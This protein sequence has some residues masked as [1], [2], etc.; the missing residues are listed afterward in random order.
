MV[1]HIDS[2]EAPGLCPCSGRRNP[3]E[4]PSR[5]K[6]LNLKPLNLKPL[7][8]KPLGRN[9]VIV[10]GRARYVAVIPARGGSKG[11]SR[12]N[13][14]S[15]AGR[16]LLAWTIDAAREAAT[17]LRVV[18]STD[19]E[20]IAELAVSLGAEVPCLRPATLATDESPSEDALLDA[21][22]SLPVSSAI[23]AVV[24]LQPTSPVRLAGSID[25][26]I[27]VF[28]STT[29]DSLVSV[30][31]TVPFLWSGSVEVPQA[32]YDIDH[33][34][35]RQD[36]S[37][38][39]RRYRE[40]GSIYVTSVDVL[41]ERRNRLGGRMAMLVMDPI[42]GLDIDDEVDLRVASVLLEGRG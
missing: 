39:Q 42:E 22:D 4:Y 38:E 9:V 8:L 10:T 18:V 23:E 7:N 30:V 13:L 11:V 21:L 35:R 3:S 16:P 5:W 1:V 28:E 24:M 6:P 36:L 29:A 15:V 19:D 17:P 32:H 26:A 20:E 34:L 12:K 37:D 2:A 25:A 40:N 41:R 27:E 33:R 14:R 31:E